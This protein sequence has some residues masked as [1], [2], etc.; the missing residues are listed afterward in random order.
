MT[1]RAIEHA[2]FGAVTPAE[3]YGQISR[4]IRERNLA[5][6]VRLDFAWIF[7]RKPGYR[8]SDFGDAHT[9]SR[10]LGKWIAAV[11]CERLVAEATKF[12]LIHDERLTL[13]KIAN[14]WNFPTREAVI[15]AYC[16]D[17]DPELLLAMQEY[18]LEP[19]W[20]YNRETFGERE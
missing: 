14:I 15:V 18:G 6:E 13:C 12:P 3:V 8:P 19:R 16:L 1:G 11:P 20:K 17:R 9:R 7:L 2:P 10:R 4:A 5:V